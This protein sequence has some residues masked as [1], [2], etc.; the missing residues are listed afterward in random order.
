L[1]KEELRNLRLRAL[2]K[3]KR[4]IR[5]EEER[6]GGRKKIK[7]RREYNRLLRHLL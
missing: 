2:R 7:K 4:A 5:N 6:G 1:S 3:R